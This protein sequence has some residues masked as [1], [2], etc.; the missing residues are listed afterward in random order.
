M[1]ALLAIAFVC[2][3]TTAPQSPILAQE[4]SSA[5]E[6]KAIVET[7]PLFKLEGCPA[8]L[9]QTKDLTTPGPKQY[10]SADSFDGVQPAFKF[11]TFFKPSAAKSHMRN[12]VP[13]FEFLRKQITSPDVRMALDVGAN[14]G[15]YTYFLAALGFQQVH[16]FEISS[17]NFVALQHGKLYNTPELGARV[18]PHMVGLSNRSSQFN[19]ADEGTSYGTHLVEAVGNSS[20]TVQTTTMDCFLLNFHQDL[21][22]NI[23]FM[24]IDTEGFEMAVLKGM[25]MSLPRLLNLKQIFMEIGPNRW[26]RSGL[27]I[28][29][30]VAEI[31]HLMVY[32]PHA[33]IFTRNDEAC[34]ENIMDSNTVTPS[35]SLTENVKMWK[36][37]KYQMHAIMS[38]ME[39]MGADCNFWFSQTPHSPK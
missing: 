17:R 1:V 24:K 12:D 32:L 35:E 27:S 30:G 28:D 36:I 26:A 9:T 19:L 38:K 15:F 31:G 25:H 37:R 34:P 21:L 7:P 11:G 18:L 22:E 33:F 8:H 4:L 39:Q 14:Q 5:S 10:K 23:G 20:G 2:F 3:Q 16:A 6:T 29:E 13:Y